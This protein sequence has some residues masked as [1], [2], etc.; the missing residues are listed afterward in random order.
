MTNLPTAQKM[1]DVRIAAQTGD[2]N[3]LTKIA[4]ANQK[5]LHVPDKLGWHPLHE[6]VRG[7]SVECVQVLLINGADKNQKTYT[8]V[9][10]LNIARE[11]L[12][13]DHNMTKF[14]V[15]LGAKDISQGNDE[16]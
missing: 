12:G 10:P 11:Y 5:S 8:G 15:E 9:S 3:I 14:L 7:G 16:L 1:M 13:E 2:A 6:A 4:V